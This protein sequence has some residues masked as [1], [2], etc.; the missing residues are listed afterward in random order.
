MTNP[1]LTLHQRRGKAIRRFI[2]KKSMLTD[3]LNTIWIGICIVILL[4]PL[5]IYGMFIFIQPVLHFVIPTIIGMYIGLTY[6]SLYGFVAF[7]I[8]VW[9]FAILY[10]LDGLK[11]DIRLKMIKQDA[12]TYQR[13]SLMRQHRKFNKDKMD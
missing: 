9:Y 1:N 6:N 4:T 5:A 12:D 3:V 10:S 8:S 2:F 13:E 7:V 11:L